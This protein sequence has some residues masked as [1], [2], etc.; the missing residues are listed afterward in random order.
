[1]KELA[2]LD[3]CEARKIFDEG[4]GD[5]LQE[6]PPKALIK[7]ILFYL[8]GELTSAFPVVNRLIRNDIFRLAFP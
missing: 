4:N 2:R 6:S 7:K 8:Q 3:S 5:D 1:M